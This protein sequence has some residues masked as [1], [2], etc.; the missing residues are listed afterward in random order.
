MKKLSLMILLFSASLV[1]TGFFRDLERKR[2]D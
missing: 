2:R 1:A